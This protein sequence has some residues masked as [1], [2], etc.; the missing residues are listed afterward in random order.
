MKIVKKYMPLRPC[1]VPK[2]I[3]FA[4][5]RAPFKWAPS[6]VTWISNWYSDM[7]DEDI[8]DILNISKA[9]L[10]TYVKATHLHKSKKFKIW[11]LNQVNSS[12]K[13]TTLQNKYITP[14][15]S[16]MEIREEFN[17]N[18]Q[19]IIEYY[20]DKHYK[21]GFDRCGRLARTFAEYN[22]SNEECQH[23]RDVLYEA[24]CWGNPFRVSSINNIIL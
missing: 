6:Q 8:C 13:A 11:Q 17:D 18:Q 4:C 12:I 14:Y 21:A 10:H 1:D 16:P 19:Q 9:G 23:I 3:R 2:P 15:K 7:R 24:W 22:C 5:C 20:K